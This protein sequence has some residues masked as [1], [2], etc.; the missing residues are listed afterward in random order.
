[1]NDCQILNSEMDLFSVLLEQE[2]F[3]QGIPYRG[4]FE[5]TPRCNFNCNMCYVHLNE[6][7]I[8]ARGMELTNEEILSIAR[9]ARDEGM[10]YLTLTG[11]EVFV[12]PYFRELY[13][14]LAEMGFLIQILSNGYAVDEKVMEWLS[15]CPPYLMRFTLYGASNEAYQA[16]CGIWDGFDRVSHAID[17]V[18]EAEI[19]LYLVGTIVK[20]NESDLQAMYQFAYEKR[21]MFKH[22]IAVVNPV[23]GATANAAEHRIDISAITE[24]ERKQI[25]KVHRPAP[26]IE[27]ALQMC[28]SY[29]KG[30]SLTWDGKLQ[31]CVFMEAPAVDLREHSFSDAWN[32][33]LEELTKLEAPKECSDCRYAGFCQRCPGVLS[34]E[35]GAPDCV[36]PEF[37]KRAEELYKLY[38]IDYDGQDV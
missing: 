36:S 14:A 29:R 34:A 20:E 18:K 21:L 11:G 17:L 2:S 30:F 13:E 31:L 24:E 25:K 12:R 1:M 5:L 9:Q 37:C 32:L 23:R 38:S 6:S 27:Y 10:L 28:G 15:Q 33:L 26:K 35:C 22:T 16:V 19:P 8:K 7:Q 3:Q 4:I